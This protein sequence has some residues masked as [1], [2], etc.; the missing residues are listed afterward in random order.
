MA[1]PALQSKHPLVFMSF[2]F[3]LFILILFIFFPAKVSRKWA[4]NKDDNVI[5]KERKQ[6]E[7]QNDFFFW[8]AASGG[9]KIIIEQNQN[10]MLG[11]VAN[12]LFYLKYVTSW[13]VFPLY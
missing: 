6:I 8:E 5:S 4:P 2:S 3:I 13:V 1:C 7:I 11:E 12:V 9:F 10:E